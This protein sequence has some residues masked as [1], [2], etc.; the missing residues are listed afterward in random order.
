M[1]DVSSGSPKN[2]AASRRRVTIVV[3]VIIAAVFV[4]GA[5]AV[6][7]LRLNEASEVPAASEKPEPKVTTQP[8]EAKEPEAPEPIHVIAM[9]DMLPHDSVNANAEL[10]GGGYDYGQ[11]FAGIAPQLEA[12]DVTFCNQEVPSAGVEFG[13]SGYP[14]FNAPTEFARDLHSVVGCD[15]INLATNHN[16]D[17]GVAGIAATRAAWDGLT[18]AA[19]SGANRSAEEQRNIAT[20]EVDGV[21]IALVSFAE[22][23]NT[24]ID[25]VSMNFMG[26]DE[27]VT[28]LMAS[29][30]EAAD[31]VVVSA[32]WGTEDS[33]EVNDEQRAFASLVSQLGADVIIGTGPHVLQS[34]EWIDRPDGKRTLVWYSL[35]NMLSTQLNLDQLTG[36]I[37]GFDIVRDVNGAVSIAN[38][39]A[40]LTYM[41]YSWTAEDEAAGNLLARTD[42]SISLLR[43]AEPLLAQTR[44]GVTADEQFAASAQILG[45]DVAVRDR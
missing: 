25:N 1:P 13:I 36:V 37:A 4:G 30:R 3:L 9:G 21:R 38:P 7:L 41:H 31:V 42:L 12:A 35:G 29:A 19:V 18:P 24:P 43:D 40:E 11:F 15:L 17:K 32:H 26:D 5:V 28:E 2:P 34:A 8:A 22:F 45:A 39:S 23:S 44:F 14:T 20:Y 6:A 16:A 10:P 33:H 27:L